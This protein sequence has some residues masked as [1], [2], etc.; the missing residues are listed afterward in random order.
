MNAMLQ[1]VTAVTADLTD[2]ELAGINQI[3]QTQADPRHTA[4]YAK[5]RDLFTEGGG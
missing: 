1:I 3:V 4:G 5:A 2:A